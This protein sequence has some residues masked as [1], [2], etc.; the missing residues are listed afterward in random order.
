[1]DDPAFAQRF[2]ALPFEQQQKFSHLPPTAMAEYFFMIQH[3]TSPKKRR[4]GNELRK[5]NNST[6]DKMVTKRN[7]CYKCQ[8]RKERGLSMTPKLPSMKQILPSIFS[9]KEMIEEKRNNQ[10]LPSI[11]TIMHSERCDILPEISTE[12]SVEQLHSFVLSLAGGSQEKA[13]TLLK[14]YSQSTPL[15]RPPVF[16]VTNPN[17]FLFISGQDP[18]KLNFPFPI[19]SSSEKN[20]NPPVSNTTNDSPLQKFKFY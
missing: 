1:M 2:K 16:S 3:Q 12:K 19:T 5:C 7:Y 10:L 14:N 4:R 15:P 11:H 6:C 18:S 9:S 13:A 20:L 8:K 17:S